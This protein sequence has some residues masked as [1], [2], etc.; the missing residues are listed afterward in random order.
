M[1]WGLRIDDVRVAEPAE[2]TADSSVEMTDTVGRRAGRVQSDLR[3]KVLVA[4][5]RMEVSLEN[6]LLRPGT[7]TLDENESQ[8][9]LV[10]SRR[11]GSYRVNREGKRV[12]I[13]RPK[14]RREGQGQGQRA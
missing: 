2:I 14:W 13:N 1:L 6:N 3:L 7:Y 4:A 9:P 10:H 5:P 8:M 12:Y 11:G